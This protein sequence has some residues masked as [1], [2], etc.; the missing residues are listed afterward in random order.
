MEYYQIQVRGILPQDADD[1]V[2]RVTFSFTGAYGEEFSKTTEL[3]VVSYT[4]N[5]IDK[6]TDTKSITLM[7]SLL[8]YVAAAKTYNGRDAA[9]IAALVDASKIAAPGAATL[10]GTASD[11]RISLE[12]RDELAWRIEALADT[13]AS[14]TY[15]AAGAET[16]WSRE[17]KEGESIIIKIKAA[18][19]AAGLAVASTA[20]SA[21]VTTENYYN[22][23]AGD[24]DAQQMMAAVYAYVAAANAYKLQ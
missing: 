9:E 24:A 22:A 2:V 13:T 5:I 12:F 3:S 6:S 10:E 16:T 17:M 1:V 8:N 20:G 14:F 15:K 11:L 21:T 4:K 19:F 23:L 18:D 7:H